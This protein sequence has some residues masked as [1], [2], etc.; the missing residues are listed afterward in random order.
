MR[1]EGTHWLCDP[2]LYLIFSLFFFFLQQNNY[3]HFKLATTVWAT[4]ICLQCCVVYKWT[5]GGGRTSG[6]RQAAGAGDICD[7]AQQ[8]WM[9]D[10]CSFLKGYWHPFCLIGRM[11]TCNGL[12]HTHTHTLGILRLNESTVQKAILKPPWFNMPLGH[13]AKLFPPT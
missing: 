5:S 2:C 1:L 10:T 6:V 3:L 9:P 4:W 8:R 13:A 11:P 12:K 7:P